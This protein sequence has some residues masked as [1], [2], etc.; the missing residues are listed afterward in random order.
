LPANDHKGE[1]FDMDKVKHRNLP[2]NRDRWGATDE[3]GTLNFITAEVRAK[4]VL[5]ARSG[6][7]I[8]L[9]RPIVAS[10]IVSGPFADTSAESVS[11][12]QV[13]MQSAPGSPGTCELVLMMTHSPEI[14]HLDALSHIHR[15]GE[16]YP[17][18]PVSGEVTPAGVNRGSTAAFGE[19]ILTR[20]VLLDLAVEGPLAEGHAVTADDLRVAAERQQVEVHTGDAIIVRGGWDYAANRSRRI[21]GLDLSAVRWLH[22][23]EISVYGGDIGD[24]APP[25]DP[26]LGGPLH[27]VAIPLMGMP[28]IDV[29]DPTYLAL[30]CQD[31]E[32]YSFLFVAAP[33]RL[34]AASGVPVNPVAIF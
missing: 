8:S 18:R 16:V 21:P 14:T 1:G 9:G 22:E 6:R 19:G 3:R 4:A 34:T 27:M 12:M 33:P 13:M 30:A 10:P 31:E 32:R 25:I 23:H 29:L 26:D 17:G 5:E 28:L 20:G 24:A 2:S 11:A 7:H 15:D